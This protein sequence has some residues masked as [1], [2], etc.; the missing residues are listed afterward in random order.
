TIA[1]VSGLRR[2]CRRLMLQ[3]SGKF[4]HH[5][6]LLANDGAGC[7]QLLFQRQPGGRLA[8]AQHPGT[9]RKLNHLSLDIGVHGQDGCS[10]FVCDYV[11]A[12]PANAASALAFAASA[13]RAISS[14]D[15]RLII[16]SGGMSPARL[17]S[18]TR[19]FW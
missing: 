11:V 6:V 2:V 5:P 19:H 4:F 3:Q 16:T 8:Q 1:M 14:G 13:L 18:L 7:V 17:A 12:L 10:E 9:V 15:G